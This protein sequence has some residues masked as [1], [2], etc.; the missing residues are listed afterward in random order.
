MPCRYARYRSTIAAPWRDDAWRCITA[1]NAIH[2][3]CFQLGGRDTDLL[4]G[5]QPATGTS[6]VHATLAESATRSAPVEPAEGRAW[7][8]ELDDGSVCTPPTGTTGQIG[9][10]LVAYFCTGP[11]SGPVGSLLPGGVWRVEVAGTG[12]D[13]AV[14]F[15]TV[16][17]R[18]VWQ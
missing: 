3:P 17:I 7:L 12:A 1:G 4:C 16:A 8:F 13:G 5:P 15:E 10:R 6:G 11:T 9:G 2:D 14:V 18:T